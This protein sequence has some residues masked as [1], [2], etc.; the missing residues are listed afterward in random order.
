M[1]WRGLWSATEQYYEY[2]TI[3]SPANSATYILTGQKT[4]LG[5]G[6][7][8]TNGAWTELSASS[9]GLTS[10]LAGAGISITFPFNP[11][12]PVLNNDGVITLAI[13]G[14]LIN[15]G[16]ATEPILESSGVRTL[17][18]GDGIAVGGTAQNPTLTNTGIRNLVAGPGISVTPGN[19]PTITNTGVVAITAGNA[20]IGISGDANNVFITNTG[21]ASLSVGPGLSTTGGLNP[22]IANTGVLSV[23]AADATITVT[24]TA[25]DPTISALV[26]SISLVTA[27]QSLDPIGATI[28]AGAS[29]T[30]PFVQYALPSVFNDYLAN[31]AP[32]PNGIFMIDLSSLNFRFNYAGAVGDQRTISLAFQYI[33]GSPPSTVTY[34]SATFLNEIVLTANT[35]DAAYF[36][37]GKVYFN[38]ADARTA[39]LTAING[40][41]ITNGT[42]GT[43]TNVASGNVYAEYY[44]SGLE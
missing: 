16:T 33:V 32:N 35:T 7:P 23:A 43:V 1:N 2:D 37:F 15:T 10:I 17:T 18:G 3:I 21:L 39:G 19:N 20:G 6:D 8:S 4:I 22:T 11:Q 44:P 13:G 26:P 29:G 12:T 38:V 31:G 24:G 27:G 14:G 5:G 9:T 28:N 40:F 30:V 25:Q 36:N 41:L 42:I 34:T